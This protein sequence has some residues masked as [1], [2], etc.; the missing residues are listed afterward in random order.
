M[1]DRTHSEA[2]TS[3][4]RGSRGIETGIRLL[5]FLAGWRD[6]ASLP[7]PRT[8][9]L[10]EIASALA[11]PEPTA[12]RILNG[13]VRGGWVEKAGLEYRLAF[14]LALVG[15]GIHEAVRRQEESLKGMVQILDRASAED[16]ATRE[17][18]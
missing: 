4:L 16:K 7:R 1:P 18:N 17:L 13:L 14:R 12:Y 5:E 8:A 10:H 11:I 3:G 2:D 6:E 9:A 15:V